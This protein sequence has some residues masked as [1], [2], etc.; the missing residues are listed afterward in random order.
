MSMYVCQ[1]ADR[2]LD[3]STAR[4]VLWKK[5]ATLCQTAL[6]F[7]RIAQSTCPCQIGHC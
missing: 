5:A 6:R 7:H 3:V 2:A 4:R 1:L